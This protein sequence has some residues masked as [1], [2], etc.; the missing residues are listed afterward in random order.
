VVGGGVVVVVVPP[1]DVEPPPFA[2]GTLTFPLPPIAEAASSLAL[3]LLQPVS[4]PKETNRA[5]GA[6][7]NAFAWFGRKVRRSRFVVI[8]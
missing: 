2:G 1:V 4:N 7:F 6:D 8:S 3:E 5:S